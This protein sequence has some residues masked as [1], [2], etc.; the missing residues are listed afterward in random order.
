M[1]TAVVM[2]DKIMPRNNKSK[3]MSIYLE[4]SYLR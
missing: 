3:H 2:G 4:P 1:Y